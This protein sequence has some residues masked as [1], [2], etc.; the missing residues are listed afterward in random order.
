MQ[1]EDKNIIKIVEQEYHRLKQMAK[2]YTY[3]D[4]ADKRYY[5]A[6][7]VDLIPVLHIHLLKTEH[8]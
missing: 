2:E 8:I 6:Q 5:D 4:K 7:V 3:I 1:V